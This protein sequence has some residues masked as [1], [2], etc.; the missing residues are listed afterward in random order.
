[1]TL[2]LAQ[3]CTFALQSLKWALTWCKHAPLHSN[4]SN[5]PLSDSQVQL[6]TWNTQMTPFK[7]LM[8]TN[9]PQWLKSTPLRLYRAT[10]PQIDSNELLWN[11]NVQQHFTKT[12]FSPF[13]ALMS[14]STHKWLKWTPKSLKCAK[15][16]SYD[17]SDPSELQWDLNVQYNITMTQFNPFDVL[18]C[19]YTTKS[20]KWAPKGLK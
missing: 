19:N 3:T 7:T 5:E 8:C 2:K 15:R 4:H 16:N 14:N 12:Q 20:L 17:S 13:E 1:M 18:L 10:T 11:Q 6:C 9:T